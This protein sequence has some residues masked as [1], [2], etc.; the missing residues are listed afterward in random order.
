VPGDKKVI[1]E[2]F[3][4]GT[5]PFGQLTII[6]KSEGDADAAAAANANQPAAGSLY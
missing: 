6:G 4:Q 3:K 5:S 2:A 1:M